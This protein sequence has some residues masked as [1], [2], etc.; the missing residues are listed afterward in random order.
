MLRDS[1]ESSEDELHHDFLPYQD[2]PIASSDAE[3]NESA[4]ES[5]QDADSLTPRILEL[6][7]EG[8]ID[9]DS[10]YGKILFSFYYIF[11]EEFSRTVKFCAIV[12][13]LLSMLLHKCKCGKCTREDLVGAREFRCCHEIA[14]A[15]A[16]L[17]FDG[18]ID[19]MKCITSH[20]WRRQPDT[21]VML[22]KFFCVY[23]L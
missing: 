16:K 22:C 15:I 3:S 5:S 23:R 8:N 11:L 1:S 20:Q 7:F 2:E 12:L 6:R 14:E 9:V 13:N 18:T 10:W 19:R 21:L 17:T 4:G